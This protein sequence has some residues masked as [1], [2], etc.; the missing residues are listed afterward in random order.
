MNISDRIKQAREVTGLTQVELAEKLRVD[1]SLI[2]QIESGYKPASDHL[3]KLLAFQ[4]GFPPNF[5]RSA[6]PS[7][8]PFGSLALRSHASILSK[9]DKL[10]A[11]RYA[12]L[13]LEIAE[14]LAKSVTQIKVRLSQLEEEP[15]EAASVVRSALGLAPDKP[16]INLM[17]VLE[18]N[19]VLIFPLPISVKG[20]NAFSVLSTRGKP[21]IAVC[22]GKSADNVRFSLA[23]ELCHLFA[24]PKG[25][26]REIE[27]QANQFSAEFLLP[28]I[29]IK[30][31]FNRPI[32][33]DFLAK[34][35]AKWRVSMQ[36]I[37]KRA[38]ELQRVTYRQYY[39]LMRQITVRGWRHKEPVEIPMERPHA[40]R[41]M[42]ELVYGTP[43]NLRKLAS[44]ISF[45][46]AFVRDV[47]RPYYDSNF[48]SVGSR[49]ARNIST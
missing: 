13:S 14:F 4:T 12:Q 40:L 34:V 38:Y 23:H 48:D 36:A 31:E 25:T 41:K 26:P 35:K 19:G 28:E 39:H 42:A 24:P 22:N 33:L 1:D 32:T 17:N 37:L 43:I 49:F 3:V 2:G 10:R 18:K 27:K 16:I 46:L 44:D 11:Y 6:V 30:D 9:R 8:L 29:A 47:F 20:L 21:I 7:D 15:H 45:P 5:F